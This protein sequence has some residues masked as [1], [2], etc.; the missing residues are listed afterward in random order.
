M[1]LSVLQTVRVWG[2]NPRPWLRAFFDAG[3]AHGGKTPPDRSAFL[4]GQM[5]DA[6]KPQLAQSLSV[7]RP[8]WDSWP[9]ARDTAV[10]ANTSACLRRGVA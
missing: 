5:T 9:P 2:L 3:V 8:P 4:P 1:M 6:R 10:V 7:P